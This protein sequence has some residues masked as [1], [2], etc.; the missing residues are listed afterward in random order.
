MLN[1]IS[2]KSGFV[3]ALILVLSSCTD[4]NFSRNPTPPESAEVLATVNGVPITRQD[5]L[6]RINRNNKD[7]SQEEPRPGMVKKVLEGI[8]LQEIVSQ[9][10]LE[11]GLDNDKSYQ[12]QLLHL[13]TQLADFNRKKLS[14][15]FYS[16]EVNLKAVVTDA[17]ALAYA[18]ENADILQTEIN[19]WQILR[20]NEKQIQQVKADLD[21]GEAFATVAAKR[22]P[23]IPESLGNPWELGYLNWQQIPAAWW[24][25]VNS[26]Q[27][28]ETSEIIRSGN[29]RFWII[30]LVD[31]RPWTDYSYETSKP[32]IKAILK[33][34][35]VRKLRATTI[36][37][38]RDSADITYT[39]P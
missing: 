7:E 27:M 16:Q 32:K 20:K 14:D 29:R 1:T 19:I 26:L 31:K 36:K 23:N 35:K 38:L 10:A 2:F 33:Q 13:Q 8:I 3:I 18:T 22:F 39:L 9:R 15:V 37:A 11:L 4:N 34:D 28:G 25:T 12:E 21:Q 5:V 17:E 6:Y 24:D 30:K